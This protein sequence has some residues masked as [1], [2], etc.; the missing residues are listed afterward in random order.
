MPTGVSWEP[1]AGTPGESGGFGPYVLDLVRDLR[2]ETGAAILLIA[3]NMGVIRTMCD[4]VGVMFRQSIETYVS[5]L[6]VLKLNAAYVPLDASFP[7]V[8]IP[9]P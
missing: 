6:A 7:P 8:M 1:L 2:N 5:L 4:R 9:R 3:H